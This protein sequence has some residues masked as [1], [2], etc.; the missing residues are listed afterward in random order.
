G[1]FVG[2]V[3]PYW[4]SQAALAEAEEALRAR[5]PRFDE[6]EKAYLRAADAATG[7]SYSPRPWL[8]MA[9]LKSEEWRARGSKLSDLRWKGIPVAMAEA[10]NPPRNPDNW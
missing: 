6:A 4:R 2:A 10:V 1:T 3:T 8:G 7:D 5:P 9:Y